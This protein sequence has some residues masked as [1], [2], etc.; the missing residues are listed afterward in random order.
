MEAPCNQLRSENDT[1]R[2]T[3]GLHY[4]QARAFWSLTL[5]TRFNGMVAP[6]QNGI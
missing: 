2:Y 5:H 3:N 4:S 1:Q 6:A